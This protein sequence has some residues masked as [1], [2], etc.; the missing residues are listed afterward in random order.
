[1]G[2]TI[3]PYDWKVCTFHK[4][5]FFWCS[6]NFGEWTNSGWKGKRQIP[7][8]SLFYTSTS[9]RLITLSIRE[10]TT[11]LIGKHHQDAEYWTSV[12]RDCIHR[13]ISQNRD[14]VIFE[15]LA[16][17]RTAPKLTLKSN[18]FVQQQQQRQS[19]P[20]EDV[21]KQLERG[22]DLGKQ[23]RGMKR[24][25]SQEWESFWKQLA[26]RFK[27]GRWYWSQLTRSHYRCTLEKRS[28]LSKNQKECKL[29]R[30]KFVFAKAQRK[31]RWYPVKNQA[32][33]SSRWAMWSW[34]SWRK[35]RFNVHH[36]YI[37]YLRVPLLVQVENCYDPTEMWWTGSKK[38]SKHRRQ[39]LIVFPFI[40][41]GRKC[42][43]Q[44]LGNNII[45]RP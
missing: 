44:I 7:T 35:L 3:I 36:V 19:I 25:T 24:E 30:A 13:V 26:E 41:K 18:W 29:I 31:T 39:V 1:M 27:S 23:E 8:C 14:R 15:G 34:L 20:K 28:E 45:T 11:T 37:T 12:T 17:P 16:T 21:K 42:A 9:W 4:G 5:I 33:L 40:T 2:S 43:V 32:V 38:H 6:I 22:C 10:Y